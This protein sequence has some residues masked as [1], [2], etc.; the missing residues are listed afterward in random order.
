MDKHKSNKPLRVTYDCLT[1]AVGS[2]IKLF[3]RGIIPEEHQE[4]AMRNLLK[5]LS[6][7]DF[8][9]SPPALGKDMHRIIREIL[10]D[11]DPYQGIK[12]EF[13]S[14]MLKYYPDLK[15]QVDTATDPFLLALRLAIA[16]NVID[17]G[18]NQS[19][20]VLDTLKQAKSVELAVDHS[21]QLKAAIKNASNLLYLADNAG[22][23][24]MDRLFLETINHP[25]VYFAV[26]GAPIINDVTIE[27]ARQTGIDKLAT[28]ISNGDNAPGTVIQ[29]VS[30]KFLEVFNS[31]DLIISK[32]QGN[33]EGLSGCDKNIYFL[34]M[35][36]CDHVADHLGVHKGDFLV[37]KI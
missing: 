35:A 9:Q 2:V 5:Y 11:P 30:T 29:S 3:N 7:V 16:G 15:A 33:Y 4:K 32:G 21:Q 6:N 26:R 24:V 36:K 20:N 18:P 13:N 28:I 31:A 10:K 1:C 34:L 8:N 37:M 12:K 22:E 27:D 19:F 14:L 23:I 17:F 25:H